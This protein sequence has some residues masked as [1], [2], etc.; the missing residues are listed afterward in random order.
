MPRLGEGGLLLASSEVGDG[1]VAKSPA[2]HRVA[3][4]NKEFSS[5]GCQVEI[6][7]PVLRLRSVL[8][9]SFLEPL[10]SLLRAALLSLKCEKKNIS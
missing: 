6:E 7:V 10:S 1:V 9:L 3:L 2:M 8:Y 4:H 5:P